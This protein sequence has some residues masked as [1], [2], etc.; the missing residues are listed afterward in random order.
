VRG[1]KI[2]AAG[3][4]GT[5]RAGEEVPV[6]LHDRFH[7]GSDT[8][9]MT[10]LVAAQLVEQ[11]KLRWDLTV[12]EVFP[13]LAAGVD[14]GLRSF[15]LEQLLSHTSGVPGD[16]DSFDALLL[17]SFGQE[18]NLDELRH[19]LGK[20][21]SPRPLAS[22]AR[23]RPTYSSLGFVLAG[24][25]L[26]RTTG[27]TWEELVTERVLAPL[28]LASAGFGPQATPGK[29]DAPLGHLVVDG[30]QKAFLAG[31]S[32]DNPL[33]IGP[34]GSVHLSILDFARAGRDGTPEK[35]RGV[36]RS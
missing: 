27:K 24:A 7:I 2:V 21:W 5:R 13:E 14:A 6:T 11:G 35:A 19:W 29:V 18:G 12:A 34:A 33:L 9:A 23:E 10:V 16:D 36:Q 31:P 22:K 3:A 28:G 1:G 32:G 26:E 17:R 15:T 8:K 20:E 30:R 4:V 25:T